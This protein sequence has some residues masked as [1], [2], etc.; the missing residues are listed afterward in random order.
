MHNPKGPP[1]KIA[2]DCLLCEKDH[3]KNSV[4]VHGLPYGDGV[5]TR[6]VV[7]SSANPA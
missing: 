3:T 7:R 4:Y 6:Q 1:M 5:T 2:I